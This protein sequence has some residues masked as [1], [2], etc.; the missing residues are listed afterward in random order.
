MLRTDDS[1]HC[2]GTAV[3]FHRNIQ[4][5]YQSARLTARL[6]LSLDKTMKNEAVVLSNVEHKDLKVDT[7]HCA[8]YGDNVNRALAF[9]TEF[10]ELHKEY[11]IL[12]YKD[13]KTSALNAHAIL[14]FDRDENLFL[15]DDGWLGNYVPAILARGPFLIGFQDQEVDGKL[16]KEP[17]IRVDMDDP[18][19]G[20]DEGQA[21]FLPF[22]GDTPYLERIM[23]TLQTIHQGVIFDKVLFSSVVSMDLLEP[24]SIEVTLSNIEQISFHD[25]YTINE[26]K[27][28]QL[29]GESLEKL[30]KA[31]VLSLAFFALSSLGNFH[32]LIALKN[33]KSAIAQ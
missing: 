20:A 9:S 6:A 12:F 22:G 10:V 26:E 11:P 31:G 23:R 28:A 8:S 24:V 18:R 3:Q 25:Y 33:K 15:G 4:M 14:G 17:I 30:N 21:V 16:R 1:L 27:L 13:P 32:R 19:V 5:R 7:R 2:V 29:D